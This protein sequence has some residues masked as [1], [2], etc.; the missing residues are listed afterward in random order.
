MQGSRFL[1][2]PS[3]RA[4]R[5]MRGHPRTWP[6]QAPLPEPALPRWP[7]QPV[8]LLPSGWAPAT[9]RVPEGVPFKVS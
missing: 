2:S 1:L 4:I 9:G 3:N 7:L 6:P 8:A 5:K